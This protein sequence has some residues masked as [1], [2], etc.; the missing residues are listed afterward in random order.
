VETVVAA[1]ALPVRLRAPLPLAA[2]LAAMARD[3][4]VRAGLPRFVVLKS[5]GEAATQDG[6]APALAEAA[7]LEVG[8]V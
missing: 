5:L 7:F 8:A 4:K 6:V 1:H 2:L 3:K